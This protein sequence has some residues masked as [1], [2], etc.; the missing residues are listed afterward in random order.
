MHKE[1]FNLPCF[2]GGCRSAE[3]LYAKQNYSIARHPSG[4]K[5][6]N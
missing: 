1:S 4:W 3:G 2:L 5:S 6:L